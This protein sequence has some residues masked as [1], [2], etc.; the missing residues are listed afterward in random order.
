MYRGVHI[1][2]LLFLTDFNKTWIFRQIFEKFKYQISLKFFQWEPGWFFRTDGQTHAHTYH[3]SMPRF[4]ASLT[5]FK[6][7]LP[8]SRDY[9]CHVI[10]THPPFWLQKHTDLR[11]HDFAHLPTCDIS[12]GALMLSAPEAGD[13]VKLILVYEMYSNFVISAICYG[14]THLFN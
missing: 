13:F 9:R 1:K 8:Q 3:T 4:R 5:N 10:L 12:L 14:Q 7:L 11:A 6:I 2:Y